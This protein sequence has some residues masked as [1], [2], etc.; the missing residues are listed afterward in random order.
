[1]DPPT[2]DSGG[3][4][5]PGRPGSALPPP[6]KLVAEG[7]DRIWKTYRSWALTCR[8]EERERYASL[9]ISRLPKGSALLDLGCGPGLPVTARLAEHF[10][11]TG[12]DAS[13]KQIEQARRD[14]PGATFL[15]GD[16]TRLAFPSASFDAVI[17]YYSII[18]VPREEHVGLFRDIASWLRPGGLFAGAF[19]THSKESDIDGDWLG[20]PMFWSSFDPVTTQDLLRSA[21]LEVL[22]AA[23]ETAE[24]FGRPITFC[25]IVA[26]KTGNGTI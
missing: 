25:W 4:P 18:H 14:V 22:S 1:V 19:G 16:M 26:Q 21:G 10:R 20:A 8:V 11:L 9:L 17:A 13:A 12:V 24:E 3:G 7:Y 5:R 2:T 15:V 6:K 23:E